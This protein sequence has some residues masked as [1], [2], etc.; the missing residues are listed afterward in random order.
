MTDHGPQDRAIAGAALAPMDKEDR[1]SLARLARRAWEK[2]RPQTADHRPLSFDDWRH[3]QC[4]LAVERRG[5]RECRREDFSFLRSHFLR[6]LGRETEA[7]HWRDR[8]ATEPKRVAIAKLKFEGERA[9]DVIADPGSYVSAIAHSKFKTP[10]LNEL[11]ERQIWTLVFDLRRGA[12]KKRAK[13]HD[14]VPF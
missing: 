11:S 13:H 3:Q 8:G 5:L 12:Q 6:M 10:D 9:R 14:D 4:N 2:V 1:Q 7:R